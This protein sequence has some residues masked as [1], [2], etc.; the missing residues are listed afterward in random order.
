M[1]RPSSTVA[2]GS[3]PASAP[4][5]APSGQKGPCASA[6]ASQ[7]REMEGPGRAEGPWA[8]FCPRSLEL[9]F[10]SLVGLL[11]LKQQALCSSMPPSDPREV[12]GCTRHVC[13]S[14]SGWPL[15]ISY[16]IALCPPIATPSGC[17]ALPAEPDFLPRDSGCFSPFLLPPASLVSVPASHF[18]FPLDNPEVSQELAQMHRFTHLFILNLI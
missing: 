8:S 9:N 14:R 1:S 10:Q 7:S 5:A 6:E 3:A 11:G 2:G 12:P 16:G 4:T 17:P 15:P 13:V 18:L